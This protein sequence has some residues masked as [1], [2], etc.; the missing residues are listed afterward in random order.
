ML[1]NVKLI[2]EGH[3][4]SVQDSMLESVKEN[5]PPFSQPVRCS[6]AMDRTGNTIVVSLHFEGKFQTQCSR[7]LESFTVPISSDLRLILKEEAGKFGPPQQEDAVDFYFDQNHDVVDLSFAIFDE[8]LTAFPLKP[9]CSENCRGIEV[10]D[11]DINVSSGEAKTKE[12]PMDPRWEALKKLKD[13][14]EDG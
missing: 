14:S 11:P 4:E 12:K 10:K 3:S 5:L 2:P 8:I 13:E 1:I 6:A 7:C 9:L